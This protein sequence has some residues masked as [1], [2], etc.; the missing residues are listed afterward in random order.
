M[1]SEGETL[2]RQA[3]NSKF[4]GYTILLVDDNPEY[5]EA[6]RI[7]LAH[8]GHEVICAVDGL[9]A[10]DILHQRSVDLALLDYYTSAAGVS[11]CLCECISLYQT[12]V[13]LGRLEKQAKRGSPLPKC[14]R[15]TES[16]L[17]LNNAPENPNRVGPDVVHFSMLKHAEGTQGGAKNDMNLRRPSADPMFPSADMFEHKHD[18]RE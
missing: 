1:G 8:E 7:L 15:I 18:L 17:Y 10:L 11:A 4:S 2:M 16:T 5:L 3:K 13:R 14:R 6:T 9:A 12:F